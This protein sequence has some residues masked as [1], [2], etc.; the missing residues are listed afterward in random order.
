MTAW[1]LLPQG[2]VEL[3]AETAKSHPLMDSPDA[4]LGLAR[5]RQ[6]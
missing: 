4:Q 1:L 2:E 6:A 3:Q 5:S